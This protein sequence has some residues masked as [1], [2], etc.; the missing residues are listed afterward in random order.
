[1]HKIIAIFLPHQG[2]P[3]RC[4]FCHQPHITGIALS[5]EVTPEDIRQ[6]IEQALHEPKSLRQGATFEVAFYGGTFTGL[7]FDVQECFLATVQ[8]YI[9]QGDIT[10]IRIS[11]HPCLFD[12][13]IFSL[14]ESYTISLI[15]L[16]IQSF[17]DD[18]LDQANRGYTARQATMIVHN[19]QARKIDVGIH[20]MIGLPGDSSEK[21]LES[22][23]KSITLRP[24]SVRLHPTLV[25]QGTRLEQLFQKGKYTPLSLDE[26][27]TTCKEMLQ[28]FRAARIPV[29]R[30]GLQPTNSM[31]QHIVAGPHHPAIRQ[32]VESAIFYD[33]M[34]SL[35]RKN[36]PENG[37]VTFS[38]SPR[39]VSMARGQKNSN[40]TKLRDTF[41][42]E[43]I[44]ILTDEALE[45]QQIRQ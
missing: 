34:S 21:S 39:D 8:P 17:D 25:I 40:L 41:H 13:R 6:Q 1:M 24:A 33:E 5:T 26:A 35:C 15:E 43:E 29:I 36:P 27:I 28:L 7:P 10:G 12:D 11:T 9:E 45:R 37:V 18:V 31:E 42:L 22:A 20:L 3:R 14:L 30:I 4:V 32:L 44:R 23:R 38:V 19:L 16:G 2:C